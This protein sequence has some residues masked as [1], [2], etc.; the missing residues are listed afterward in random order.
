MTDITKIW[1]EQLNNDIVPK[2]VVDE[3]GIFNANFDIGRKPGNYLVSTEL[4]GKKTMLPAYTGQ[5]GCEQDPSRCLKVRLSEHLRKWLNNPEYHLGVKTEEL[6]G[7][8]VKLH[9]AVLYSGDCSLEFRKRLEKASVYAHKPFL[10]FGP[11]KKY[12]TKYE[13]EDLSI[14][15]FGGTRRKAFLAR[16]R[17]SGVF[18]DSTTDTIDRIFDIVLG[19]DLSGIARSRSGKRNFKTAMEVRK[20]IANGSDEYLAIK[21]I[22]DKRLFKDKAPKRGCSY[23]YITDLL[24]Y[25]IEQTV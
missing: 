25:A 8:K 23:S 16:A 20:A 12:F 6:A 9:I 15:P 14:V 13:G 1:L 4:V 17:Q 10:Q 24:S 22:I 2:C 18:L 19:S 7:G 11:W 21:A 3:D 5:T